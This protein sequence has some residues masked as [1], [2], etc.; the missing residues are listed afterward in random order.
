MGDAPYTATRNSFHL[1]RMLLAVLVVLTHAYTLTGLA[2]PLNRL[3]GGQMNEGSLA[4]DGFLVISGFLICQSGV[5]NRNV[6][7]FLRNRVL[8][9]LPAM[10]CALAFS[11]LL[12][13]G[14]AYGGTYRE[15]LNLGDNGPLTWMW[16]WL[17]L[18]V[19]GEQWGIS[20]VFSGNATTSLNVSLWTIKHEVFLYLVMALLILTTLNRR[21][22]V[23]IVL[24]LF[25]LTLQ[26][27]LTVFGVR[28]WDVAD[29]RWWVLSTWNYPRFVETGVY[30]FAGTLLYAHRD[31]IPRRWYLAVISLM[32]M[33]LGWHFG[34]LREVFLIAYPYLLCYLAASP[35]CSG[36]SRIGDLSLGMYLY[37][38]PVQQLGYH[39]WPDMHPLANFA[40][41][42]AVVL[43][44]AWWSWRHVEAPV[45]AWK[46]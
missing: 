13:G 24:Y 41:T 39:L 14:L 40:F 29:V 43:P 11:A 2:T 28:V 42:L 25:F 38:Y 21:R 34:M 9:L 1:A 3:T 32:T 44:I 20:G 31:M 35:L 22:P 15:Y 17:T 12:V 27:L 33:V 7:K 8:R 26:V 4:V 45:L 36:F 18:N 30:F 46:R 19:Q 6:L 5:R 16:N 37:A 10:L 23:Y